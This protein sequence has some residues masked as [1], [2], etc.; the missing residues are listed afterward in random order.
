MNLRQPKV[1]FGSSERAAPIISFVPFSAFET[2]CVH[3]CKTDN[4]KGYL[5]WSSERYLAISSDDT[6]AR[7][8]FNQTHLNDKREVIFDEDKL[9]NAGVK[10]N[11]LKECISRKF[12]CCQD[13]ILKACFRQPRN[14]RVN[15]GAEK[16]V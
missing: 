2:F 10:K 15:S 16:R 12:P 7:E 8:T 9:V 5:K 11:S 6:K 13:E 1:F 3:V 14:V 4:R